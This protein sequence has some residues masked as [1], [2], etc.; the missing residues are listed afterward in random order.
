[1]T[2]RSGGDFVSPETRRFRDETFDEGRICFFSN[3]W[4]NQLDEGSQKL[5]LIKIARL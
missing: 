2:V 3:G 5:Q 4:F 1:M